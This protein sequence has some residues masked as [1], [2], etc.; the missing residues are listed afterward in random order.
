M[1][2]DIPLSSKLKDELLICGICYSRYSSKV[3]LPKLLACSH[4][5]CAPCIESYVTG[6]TGNAQASF[7]C[8]V[9]RRETC[10]GA[11]GSS[12]LP[13]NFS[14]I[15]LIEILQT[16]GASGVMT[17]QATSPKCQSPDGSSVSST[18]GLFHVLSSSSS[19]MESDPDR[20]K[21]KSASRNLPT[22]RER[23]LPTSP[24]SC[25]GGMDCQCRVRPPAFKPDYN[26]DSSAGR[27]TNVHI[28]PHSPS[29]PLFVQRATKVLMEPF[30]I[31]RANTGKSPTRR[32]SL[33]Q[34]QSVTTPPEQNPQDVL[35]TIKSKTDPQ[36]SSASETDAQCASASETS[37]LRRTMLSAS[38]PFRGRIPVRPP[39]RSFRRSTS[40][41]AALKCKRKIGRFSNEP[42][43][44]NAF[45][46]PTKVAVSDDGDIAVIDG[47]YMTVQLFTSTGEHISLFTVPGAS[48]ACFLGSEKVVV[49][50]HQ[51]NSNNSIYLYIAPYLRN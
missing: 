34:L 37:P 42:M 39:R 4:T 13:N 23:S 32:T 1:S 11:D 27:P 35:P 48:S 8:P 10:L 7:A 24:D 12:G 45:K 30:Q 51:G 9:C 43:T 26:S 18:R 17:E 44:T 14:L 49:G 15:S 22:P 31:P 38:M 28:L 19:G 40:E 47:I 6:N 33:A 41:L 29:C 5:F 2:D 3:R 21:S 25:S 36:C 20:C 16:Q 46:K 50:T